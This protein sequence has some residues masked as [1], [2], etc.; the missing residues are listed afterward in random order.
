M[1]VPSLMT[2]VPLMLSI[3]ILRAQSGP[4]PSGHWEGSIQ[5]PDRQVKMEI[6]LAKTSTGDYAATFSATDVKGYPLSDVTVKG[7]SISFVLKANSGGT[8]TGT[9]SADGMSLSGDYVLTEGGFSVPFSLTR[10]GTAR[11]EGAVKNA[12]ITRQLEGT[13]N[14]RLMAGGAEMRLVLK[15]SN[16]SDGTSTGFVSNLDQGGVEI[17]ITTITQT[18]S[19]VRLDVQ[20]VSGVYSGALNADGTELAGTWTQTGFEGPLTFRRTAADAEKN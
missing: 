2:L 13:W 10:T 9:L 18:A 11:L 20:V 4:D 7:I 8:F 12:A 16:H 3:P 6:D 17:P 19:S 5:A 1:L 14:A 15:L